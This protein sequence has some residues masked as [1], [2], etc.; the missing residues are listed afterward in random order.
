MTKAVLLGLLLW[1]T[2]SVMRG[3]VTIETSGTF[4]GMEAIEASPTA[5]LERTGLREVTA[6]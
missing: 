1:P 5:T 4:A 6:T 3:S 2:V